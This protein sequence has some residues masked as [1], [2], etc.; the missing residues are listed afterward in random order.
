MEKFKKI[1]II[2]TI[3]FL[4]LA[5]YA[6]IEEIKFGHIFWE[7]DAI[8]AIFL[9]G[10][11]YSIRKK[12]KLTPLHYT[13][14]G[15]ILLAHLMGIFGAYTLEF[16][17]LPYDVYIHLYFGLVLGLIFFRMKGFNSSK[18]KWFD[19][20]I[21]VSIILGISAIHEIFEYLGLLVIGTGGGFLGFGP[22]DGGQY[23]IAQ[24]LISNLIGI[25]I[26]SIIYIFSKKKNL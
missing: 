1:F 17:R 12:L 21:I 8:V 15:T 10:I 11:M 14:F 9:M 20:I 4:I 26:G 23:D 16:F 19:Y 6:L 25:V 2:S 13:L 5:I 3:I 18:N 22:G 7:I 24:D